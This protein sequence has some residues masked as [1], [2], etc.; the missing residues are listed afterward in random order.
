MSC[1]RDILFIMNRSLSG[2]RP[3]T[4]FADRLI[5]HRGYAGRY[6]ENTMPA[7]EAA[8]AAGA[9]NIELD[10]QLTA[11]RVP[12]LFHDSDLFRIMGVSGSVGEITASEFLAK[13]AAYRARFGGKFTGTRPA[14]LEHVLTTIAA[15]HEVTLFLEIKPVTLELFGVEETIE[16][17]LNAVRRINNPL[18]LLSFI[19]AAVQLVREQSSYP[20]GWVLDRFDDEHRDRAGALQPDFLFCNKDKIHTALW[21][22]VWQWIVYEVE[23]AGSAFE[24][25]SRGAHYVESMWPGELLTQASSGDGP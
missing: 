1:F 3:S 7:I 16:I 19:L 18:V 25:L 24:W 23:T 5:A 22:G 12:V 21:P 13:E 20:T 4:D 2:Q 14:T 11:D 15:H 6:P 8:L 10:L 17:V 9:R